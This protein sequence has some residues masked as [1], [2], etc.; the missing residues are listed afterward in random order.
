MYNDYVNQIKKVK[1]NK[2]KTQ[3]KS[4]PILKKG[5]LFFEKLDIKDGD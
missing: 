3:K 1:R 2:F 4:R 5:L